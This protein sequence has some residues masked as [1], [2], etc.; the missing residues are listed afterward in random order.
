MCSRTGSC[1]VPRASDI[2]IVSIHCK[3]SLSILRF[4]SAGTV[5]DC[6]VT[7][8]PLLPT[9][10]DAAD[11]RQHQPSPPVAEPVEPSSWKRRALGLVAVGLVACYGI[12]H[13]SPC[14]TRLDPVEQ[15]L[16]LQPLTGKY[17]VHRRKIVALE[18]T[19]IDNPDGHN[20]FAE[21]IRSYYNN[22]IYQSN[23]SDKIELPGQV[24]FPRLEKGRVR[25][26]FWS[27]YVAW[28][29]FTPYLQL[30]PLPHLYRTETNGN[31]PSNESSPSPNYEYIHDTLQQIDL[32]HRLATLYPEHLTLVPNTTAFRHTFKTSPTRIAS[33][34]G[35]EGLHQI[36]SSA[37][38][39][40]LYHSLGV[41]YA[42]LTG[43][44]HN[45]YA[46]SASPAHP[47]HNGLP[48][49][50]R[51][52]VLEMNRLG[53]AVDLAH[54]SVKTMHDTLDT[55]KA[56][57]IFSHSSAY[58]LCNHPR[59]VPDDILRRL[60]ENGGVVMI[61]FFPEYTRCDS[62]SDNSDEPEPE[63]DGATLSDVADHI[64]YVGEMI[65]YKHVGLGSDFDGMGSA[66]RGLE[67]VSKY[68]DLIREL[69]R[70]GVGV[71][72]VAG[73]IGGNVLRVMA[74]VEDVAVEMVKEGVKPLED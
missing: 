50:G 15:V 64:Q 55:T 38:A 33:F 11:L 62:D 34:L 22:H 5:V 54:V 58:A 42:T 46:D 53:M 49:A 41:R 68:P 3:L 6:L 1:A 61:T 18:D 43:F 47:L 31:S 28:Y 27:V 60:A 12:A 23:F 19:L 4:I 35:I 7:M 20:D 71:R 57:V 63:S 66:V 25:G 74:D 29:V 48:S 8:P 9:E 24:D 65:G 69:L 30:L 59:N 51:H 39:L 52:M 13:L 10:K 37:S 16:Q 70:R 36:G 2:S 67:D 73:V 56:P 45:E 21:F 72:D 32:I 14:H 17:T 26:Q 40:R 44:C